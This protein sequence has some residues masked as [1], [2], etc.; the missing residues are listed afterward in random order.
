MTVSCKQRITSEKWVEGAISACSGVNMRYRSKE[1][2]AS[3][4]CKTWFCSFCWL[5]LLVISRSLLTHW[6]WCQ[7][8]TTCLEITLPVSS[9]GRCD[10][11]Q[12][13]LLNLANTK[14]PRKKKKKLFYQIM[15]RKRFCVSQKAACLN[16]L[17]IFLLRSECSPEFEDGERLWGSCLAIGSLFQVTGQNFPTNSYHSHEKLKGHGAAEGSQ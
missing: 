12:R 11:Y 5:S 13:W 3:G 4:S 1:S 10:P 15:H 6:H 8:S 17:L 2:L 16:N 7:N 14:S 9:T